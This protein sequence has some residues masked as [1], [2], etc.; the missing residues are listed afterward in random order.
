M[1]AVDARTLPKGRLLK[2]RLLRY[3]V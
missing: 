3:G 1:K 2:K